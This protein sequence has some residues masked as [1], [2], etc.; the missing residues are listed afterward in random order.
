MPL[1]DN[2]FGDDEEERS[3]GRIATVFK[4]LGVDNNADFARAFVYL[5]QEEQQRLWDYVGQS[6]RAQ[7][8]GAVNQARQNGFDEYKKTG[9]ESQ[10]P[11]GVGPNGGNGVSAGDPIV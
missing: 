3:G 1:F 11:T 5:D 6:G 4:Q 10:L 8:R 2:P 7:L 9:D